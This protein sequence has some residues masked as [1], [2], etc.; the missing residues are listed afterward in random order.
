MKQNLANLEYT[1]DETLSG[2]HIY[3]KKLVSKQDRLFDG[4][5]LDWQG[6]KKHSYRYAYLN[7]ICPKG[8]LAQ[9][10]YEA[11]EF[12]LFTKAGRKIWSKQTPIHHFF[13][14]TP[15]SF[16]TFGKETH[17]YKGRLV[18]F[19]TIL[20]FSYSGKLLQTWSAY[21]N[22]DSVQRLHKKMPLDVSWFPS[23]MKRKTKSPWGGYYDYYRFNA[24]QVLPQ[25]TLGKKDS[26]FRAG[27]WLVSAR[28][29]SLLF[30]IDANTKKI[31]WSMT[32]FDI[33]DELQGQH[34]AQLRT[35]GTILVFDNGR[36]RGWSRILEFHPITKDIMFEYKYDGFFTQSRGHVAV[37]KNGNYLITESEKGRIFELTPQKQIVWEYYH[38]DVQ[39]NPNYPQSKGRREWI[40]QARGV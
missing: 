14:P 11:T 4:T 38:P 26:R 19:D 7:T 36:Y 5:L 9:K 12:G 24:I 25:N 2:V 1:F 33:A 40:Y 17:K 37:L 22:L 29:G 18:D 31:V 6:K 21:D 30:I 20:E 34:A 35:N 39:D 23:G 13:F 8:I 27:N 28:H 32:Q 3:N 16:F 15:N 10:S